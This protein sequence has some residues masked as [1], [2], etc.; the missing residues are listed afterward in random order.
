MK[1]LAS[2]KQS[3]VL[4]LAIALLCLGLF[5]FKFAYLDGIKLPSSPHASPN[6]K[7]SYQTKAYEDPALELSGIREIPTILHQSWKTNQL[8]AVNFIL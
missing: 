5:M 4:V 7:E 8:P 1:K 3:K 2:L 6:V